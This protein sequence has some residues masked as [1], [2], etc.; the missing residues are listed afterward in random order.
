MCEPE[1]NIKQQPTYFSYLLRLWQED[2]QGDAWRMSLENVHN[3]ELRGFAKLNDLFEFLKHE[4]EMSSQLDL[5]Q[6]LGKEVV[7][8]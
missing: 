2:E 6:G 1:I 7:P 4:I 5:D 8:K 3:G